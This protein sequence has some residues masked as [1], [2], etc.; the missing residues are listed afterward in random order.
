MR[1]PDHD[2]PAKTAKQ[3]VAKNRSWDKWIAE[4]NARIER[5]RAAFRG[6][7]GPARAE[8]EQLMLDRAWELLDANECEAADALLEFV[9]QEAAAALLDEYF[10]ED[11]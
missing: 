11:R 5:Q 3:K 9:P 8:L 7:L 1:W 6:N 4:E 2:M 10:G